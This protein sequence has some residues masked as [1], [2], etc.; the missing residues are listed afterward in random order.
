MCGHKGQMWE[1]ATEDLLSGKIR[2]K[3]KGSRTLEGNV[4]TDQRGRDIEDYRCRM[5]FRISLRMWWLATQD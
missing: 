3:S 1:R 2:K 4:H 5:A